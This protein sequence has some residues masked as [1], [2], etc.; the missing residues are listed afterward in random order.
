M[1]KVAADF[2]WMTLEKF[3]LLTDKQKRS[4]AIKALTKTVC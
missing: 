4:K 2:W 1:D 3:F